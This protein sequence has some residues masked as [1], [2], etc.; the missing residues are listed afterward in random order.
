[1]E[2]RE[3][4]RLKRKDVDDIPP[5]KLEHRIEEAVVQLRKLVGKKAEADARIDPLR[6]FVSARLTAAELREIGRS[7]QEMRIYAVWQSSRKAKLTGRS[8]GVLKA[9]AALT[10]FSADGAGI[11]WAVLDTGVRADHPHFGG[12]V[13]KEVWDCTKRGRPVKLVGHK[14]PDGHGTHVCGIIAGT[15]ARRKDGRLPKERGVAPRA[16]LVVYKF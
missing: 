13:I 14:D 2:Q 3:Q 1:V 12:V 9:D 16:R 6:R 7:Y 15:A 8:M 10:S 5:L 11:T 4:S